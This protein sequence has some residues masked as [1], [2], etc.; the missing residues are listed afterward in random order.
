[1]RSSRLLAALLAAAV[2]TGL[3][4]CSSGPSEPTTVSEQTLSALEADSGFTWDKQPVPLDLGVTHTQ[5]SL[6][7]HD[8]E[9]ATDRGKEIL[10]DDG[11]IWQNNHLMGFGTDNPEPSP[12]D[13][14]WD[15]LDQRMELTEETG[16]K[17][18]LTLCCAPDWMKG[19]EEDETDW[20]KLED[21]PLPEHF[22]DYA[23]LA[24][25]AV[26]RYPQ[27]DR[28]L[29]WNEL[30]GFYNDAANRWDYEGY[31][32]FYNQVYTA[33]KAVRPDI[34]VG[35]PYVVLISLDPGT[36]DASPQVT[37]PWGAADQRTLD[38]VDYWLQ[39][40]VGA[41]FIA[42]DASTKTRNDT[43]PSV[44]DGAQKYA[45]LDRWLSERSRAAGDDLPIWWAEFYPDVPDDAQPGAASPA[46]AT[47]TLAAVAAY[48]RSGAAGALLW[49]PQ[50]DPELHYAALWTDATKDDGGRPTPLT[51]AWQ[52]LVP[53]LAKG[54]VEIG[55][56]ATSPMLVFRAP[57]GAVVV[58]ASEE[59]VQ[60][61]PDTEAV[62]PWSITVV[63]RS[64]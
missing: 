9:E 24:A 16:G 19:G 7:S 35:G 48:A 44:L 60:V 43:V 41:D 10:S 56:S 15:S 46:S 27:V 55:H 50:G 11:A 13:Y 64:S 54:D 37:G 8:P 51:A 30:K 14:D 38:V 25:E 47:A 28:V 18:M 6:G 58:N 33:V 21:N 42:V 2:V 5:D 23:N 59:S 34:Q 39:H 62:G 3:A 53:R 26:K 4:A 57:D 12:G 29:V 61:A 49:G 20:S 17:A 32:D 36:T 52:W 45:D 63:P 22:A 31:T 1:M 40:K